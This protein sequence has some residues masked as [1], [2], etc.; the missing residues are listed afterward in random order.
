MNLK[1]EVYHKGEGSYDPARWG[2][3]IRVACEM[4][5]QSIMLTFH[6]WPCGRHSVFAIL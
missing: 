1:G 6:S 5:I 2:R 3:R 4:G